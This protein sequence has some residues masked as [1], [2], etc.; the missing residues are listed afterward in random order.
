MKLT[1]GKFSSIYLVEQIN[2]F[3]VEE[4][5]TTILLHKDLIRKIEKEF[6]EEIAE[7]NISPTSYKDK[8][9]RDSKC[10]ELDY[11]QSV[12]ILVAESKTVRKAVIKRIEELENRLAN[13]LRN[14]I[15]FY[16]RYEIN[17]QNIPAGY[18]SMIE[19]TI[20][21][22]IIPLELDGKDLLKES[23]P[24]GSLGRG[25]CAFLREKGIDTD[26]FPTYKHTINKVIVEA[27]LYKDEYFVFF[28]QYVNDWIKGKGNKYFNERTTLLLK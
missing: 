28:K 17:K 9:N 13:P 23:L 26:K 14:S 3:R 20:N 27:K 5:N 8:S 16:K 2:L 15:E 21:R 1:N 25:F 12:Q 7:R 11:K 22:V 24:D 19:E 10:Y 6:E 4:G 18:F